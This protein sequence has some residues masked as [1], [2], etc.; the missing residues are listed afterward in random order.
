MEI[1]AARVGGAAQQKSALAWITQIRLDRIKTHIGR[2]SDS[3]GTVA[4]KRF[5][6]VLLGGVADVAALGVQ[7]HRHPRSRLA[8]VRD[9]ALELVFG[10]VGGEVGNLGLEGQHLVGGGVDDGCAEVK[11]ALRVAAPMQ[12]EFGGIRI[13]A[14]AQ[15]RLVEVLRV[16]QLLGKCGALRAH[17]CILGRGFSAGGRGPRAH[18]R[19]RSLPLW[20]CA[21]QPP[22]N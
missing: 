12:R 5:G 1:I 11:N 22:G 18:G 4:H 3:I 16:A 19:G 8:Y 20:H 2:Q 13:Q 14:H 9:Q 21:H 7:N 15:E 17:R 10:A 6:R